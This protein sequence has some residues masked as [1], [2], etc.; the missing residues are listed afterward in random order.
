VSNAHIK[1]AIKPEFISKERLGEE[2]IVAR[3]REQ[4][5]KNEIARLRAD[6]ITSLFLMSEPKGVV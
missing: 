3:Y 4:L 1:P 6:F 2:L 5:R